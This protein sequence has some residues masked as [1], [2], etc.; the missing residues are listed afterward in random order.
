[1]TAWDVTTAEY[2]GRSFL[3]TGQDT[4]PQGIYIT[5]DGTSLFLVGD[6]NNSVY[7]YTLTTPFRISTA[8]YAGVS[9]SVA[10]QTTAPRGV[11]FKPDGTKMYLS[12]QE[13]ADPRIYEYSLSSAWDISTAS[14]TGNSL[15]VSF[16]TNHDLTISSDGVDV[17]ATGATSYNRI[18]H[19][20]LGT[21]WDLSTAGAIADA[22]YLSTIPNYHCG[23]DISDDD[24]TLYPCESTSAPDTRVYQWPIPGGAWPSDISNPTVPDYYDVSPEAVL[25]ESIRFSSDGEK[26]Y[27]F[28]HQTNTIFQYNMVPEPPDN[29]T[30]WS[31][32]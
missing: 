22:A 6:T 13:F 8:V 25:G 3:A 4:D 20:V 32:S 12:G 31:I 21:P 17:Y 29:P 30:T 19:Y 5:P 14:Y 1:M 2:S 26:F 9:F 15:Y 27:V 7:Q 18:H 16:I 10:G 23:I 11:F 28:D 24:A